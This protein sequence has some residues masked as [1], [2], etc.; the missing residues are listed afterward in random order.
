MCNG[1]LEVSI[2]YCFSHHAQLKLLMWLRK[3]PLRC[4]S[5]PTGLLHWV[6]RPPCNVLRKSARSSPAPEAWSAAE[7][8]RARLPLSSERK[9]RGR[10]RRC[11]GEIRRRHWGSD[12]GRTHGGAT[13]AFQKAS[14]KIPGGAL[15]LK[16]TLRDFR[17]LRKLSRFEK[18]NTSHWVL[19]LSIVDF[20]EVASSHRNLRVDPQ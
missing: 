10:P 12:Q 5:T 13:V 7:P 20:K 19:R 9:S 15:S 17:C 6:I 1:S 14:A 11:G 3:K 18:E 8:A 4:K 2:K 16:R